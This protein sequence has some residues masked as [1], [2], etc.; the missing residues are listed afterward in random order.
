LPATL[1]GDELS[2]NIH[3]VTDSITKERNKFIRKTATNLIE[4]LF[5]DGVPMP[6]TDNESLRDPF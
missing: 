3:E 1:L 5:E 6:T 4:G 2:Q